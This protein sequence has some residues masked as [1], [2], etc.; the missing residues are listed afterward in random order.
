[1]EQEKDRQLGITFQIS[2]DSFLDEPKIVNDEKS[3]QYEQALQVLEEAK[4]FRSNQK[5][6]DIAKQGLG[7]C[8]DCIEAYLVY[9]WNVQDI[10]E[11]IHILRQGMELATMNIGKEF[12]L[13]HV[14]DFYEEDVMKPLLQIKFAYALSLYEAGN[15]KKA[16][17]QFQ[18][19]LNLNPSDVFHVKHYVYASYLYFEQL[20][21]CKELLGRELHEDTF[22]MY[23]RFLLL[24]KEEQINEAKAM[25][26]QLAQANTHL[27]DMLT[28]RMMNTAAIVPHFEAGSFEEAAYIYKVLSKV[29][30]TLEY[31]PVFLMKYENED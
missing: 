24:M 4:R 13:R 27:F 9:G 2:L 30:S 17:K 10:Y 5:K 22:L 26:T 15:L 25:V 28:Y 3:T 11:R 29:I 31:L 14:A 23:V 21:K 16:Q 1:M 8:G 12:F 19:I 20:E 6:C 18:E 7:I